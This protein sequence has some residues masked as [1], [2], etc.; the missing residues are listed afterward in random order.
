MTEAED[1]APR[2]TEVFDVVGPL[3]RL[4]LR[5]VERDAPIEGLSVGM[6]A[7]LHLLRQHGPMTV[8]DMGRAQ[9][10]SRQF[11]QRM[12]NDAAAEH[13][14]ETVPNPAHK[15]SSLIRLT[16]RG[17]TVIDAVIARE[18]AALRRAGADLT[19]AEV[20]ACLRVLNRML[21][22]LDDE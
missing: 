12:V 9:A 16:E 20:T 1:L 2:L 15:R 21:H 7:V 5:R 18:H 10:L 4:A 8:P 6:R 3:Y 22:N 17:T 13:L 19:D 11:V 14:V